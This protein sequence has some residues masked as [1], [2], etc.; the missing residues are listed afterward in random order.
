MYANAIGQREVPRTI[1]PNEL[2][3]AT[4]AQPQT[5]PR[6]IDLPVQPR[7]P[8]SG[9]TEQT[10]A[11]N[12]DLPK[13]K[14]LGADTA[15]P[16]KYGTLPISKFRTNTIERSQPEEVLDQLN[17]ED[18]DFVPESKPE[19]QDQAVKNIEYDRDKVINDIK[20]SKSISG[21]VQAHEAAIISHQLLE[22]G[23]KTG[24]LSEYT[25]FLKTVT[26]KTREAARALK[27]TDTAWDK[28]TPD[29]ALLRAQRVIDEV[30]REIQKSN[31]SRIKKVEQE[32]KQVTDVI[33]KAEED[34][35][36]SLG[37]VVEKAV[38]SRRKP[39]AKLPTAESTIT[40]VEDAVSKLTD[41]NIGELIGLYTE[42][43]AKRLASYSDVMKKKN[44]RQIAPLQQAFDDLTRE[45]YKIAQETLPKVKTA[46]QEVRATDILKSAIENKQ[47]YQDV[48][49]RAKFELKMKYADNPEALE[50]FNDF[51]DKD[52]I[53]NFSK[54]TLDTAIKQTAKDFN[55]DLGKIIKASK[56]DKDKLSKDIQDYV[57]YKVGVKGDDA[58]A[59]ADEILN[60]YNAI[61]KA[62][63]E[64]ALKQMFPEAYGKIR[65]TPTKKSALEKV[66]ELINMGA[67]DNEAIKNV[68][69]AKN[70]IP[71]LENSD[72]KVIV[73]NM[74]LSA[75]QTDPYMKRMYSS[76]AEQIIA[77]KVPSDLVEKL[78]AALTSS[79]LLN[80][81]TLAVKNPGGNT[82]LRTLEDISH[83]PATGVDKLVS[84]KTGERSRTINP[85]VKL[86][87]SAKGAKQGIVEWAKDIKY[88]VD[89][90]PT[91]GMADLPRKSV[92]YSENHNIANPKVK[93]VM[94]A[95]GKVGNAVYQVV[96]H[97]LKLG[98]RPFYQA[99]YNARIAE[100]EAL[101]KT[102]KLY[103]DP[104]TGKTI[105]ISQDAALEGLT[106]TLQND[107]WFAK[108]FAGIGGKEDSK[109]LARFV[110]FL[111]LPF[112]Y[113]PGNILDKFIDYS[114]VGVAKATGHALTTAG[115]GTFNQKYFS[116]T[117]GRGLTGGG[118]AVLG[119]LMAQKGFVTGGYDPDSKVEKTEMA[120]G[121]TNYAFKI[122]DT[123]Q[124]FDWALP[125]SGPIAL[126]AEFYRAKSESKDSATATLNGLA[127]A[128]D[129]L[130]S[131]SV[132]QGPASLLGGMSPAASIVKTLM[133]TTSM[134]TPTGGKQIAQM[135]DDYTRETYDPNPVK[136]QANKLVARI[137]FASKTL[138]IKPD[139]FG[140]DI[141]NFQGR[142]NIANV[143]LNPGTS[144][145]Y[146]PDAA[147]KEL[148]RLYEEGGF[149]NQL[150]LVADKN[151]KV[152]DEPYIL[153]AVE[154]VRYQKTEGQYFK[155]KVSELINTKEYKS[156]SD[157]DK[158]KMI[159][160]INDA[161]KQK[162]RYEYFDNKGLPVTLVLSKEYQ[163]KY[164]KVKGFVSDKQFY[165]AVQ[166]IKG[167]SK[168]IEK[169]YAIEARLPKASDKL[170]SSLGISSE[171]V[172]RARDLKQNRIT[173]A[174][175]QT[176]LTV[177]NTNGNANVS[178]AEAMA[179]LDSTNLDVQQKYVLMKALVPSLKDK[180]N[181]Y[182]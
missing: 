2:P 87:A 104:A 3:K 37:D 129:A 55:V 21:G 105:D 1:T 77:N 5:L 22:E 72:I 54:R 75:K 16:D 60:Q 118:L 114:G 31:P 30:E 170:Y 76:R 34:T 156:A 47:N 13:F 35:I 124:T 81:K 168:D 99:S 134:V 145:K 165:A 116:D 107:S 103:T 178:K 164:D 111:I 149:T 49:E 142:N 12:G 97:L 95:A 162:A 130:F 36:E 78:K 108:T 51:F 50:L 39:S 121:K 90:S 166:S 26:E 157:T 38:R 153:S 89:T 176:A 117:M 6:A 131:L 96:G 53:P 93:A 179:Y 11:K 120:L 92:V 181:P 33:K 74:E 64:S 61:L 9:I 135:V 4:K 43:S 40:S 66:M 154:Y 67:F 136:E 46:K 160:D 182:W 143:M 150:P 133:G 102:N 167:K 161:A 109:P 57:L 147:Q 44:G 138:P 128:V 174:Q 180:N 32:T 41:K 73:E 8:E 59:L 100:L 155:S 20:N 144:T 63:T 113:T 83:I 140:N 94:D 112:K 115:K 48:W 58:K 175:Y 70:N 91:R 52:V 98:D 110:A 101:A 84:L 25:A 28:R 68:I 69:K 17:L 173:A 172:S 27:G 177:A 88:G 123:Y 126:G 85:L 42:T 23:L 146:N 132:L 119:Y 171:T 10:F 62:K 56:G 24:N 152:N 80:L 137:P 148:M 139:V 122:G 18:F 158:A 151:F 169:A 29:G 106:L 15:R 82:I 7:T 19:W 45:L 125:A 159:Q 163:E 14:D 71:V 127:G 79:M 141:K 65:S 86:P